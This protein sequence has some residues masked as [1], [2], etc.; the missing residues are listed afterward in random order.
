M[1]VWV[2][3]GWNS[4]DSRARARGRVIVQAPTPCNRITQWLLA[5]FRRG[6]NGNPRGLILNRPISLGNEL[7]L[8]HMTLSLIG[9]LRV[10]NCCCP[11]TSF[12]ESFV[13]VLHL[14]D[15]TIYNPQKTPPKR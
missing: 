8:S 12:V 9:D 15:G 2:G 13:R 11:L 6:W 14:R 7:W 3:Y 4:V 10:D 1:L 5:S